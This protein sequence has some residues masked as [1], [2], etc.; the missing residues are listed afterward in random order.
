MDVRS[1]LVLIFQILYIVTILGVTTVIISENRNP[2]KTISWILVLTFLPVIGLILY[3]FFGEDHRKVWRINKK[4]NKGLEGKDLPYFELFDKEIPNDS[5]VKL[6]TLLKNV[7]YAPVLSE[8]S[9]DILTSG[10]DKFRQLFIDINNAT[11]HVHLLYYKIADDKIG[12]ELKNLL[13]KKVADGIEVRVIYDDVGSIKTKNRFF[14]EMKEAGIKIESFLP[15]KFPYLARRVN[16][17]NHRKIAVIDG[18]IGYIGGINIA[19]CYIEGIK[20]GIWRDTTI[21]IEGKGVYGLQVIFLLDWY[22]SHKEALNTSPYFPSLPSLPSLGN[23]SMQIVSASPLE[24]YESMTEGFFQAING[25]KDYIYIQ[26]PYFIP[27]DR[28]I[29]AMQTAAMSGVDVRLTIPERSDNYFV[30]AATYSSISALLSYNVTVYLYTTGFIHSKMIVIDDSLTIIGSANMDVRSFE[31]NFEA[32][33]FI[34]SED[35][36]KKGKN[37]YLRDLEDS[38]PVALSE[39]ENRSRL[40]RYFES[41]MRL[42]TPLL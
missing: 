10:E 39:W 14:R 34:Y 41:L 32:S 6:K 25:A 20:W 11:K 42:L 9:V 5:Y 8:N 3:L 4:M 33:A 16:Y 17:R 2:Q 29:K 15:I 18:Q 35:T 38:R 22:Y 40:R 23:N 21:R 36:A 12:N 28:I 19:D 31:L 24:K 37:I 13:I 26:T 7:G 30:T 27:T 1:I